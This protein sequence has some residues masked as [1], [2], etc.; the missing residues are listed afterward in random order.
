MVRVVKKD[1]KKEAF[2][3]KKIKTSVEKA[4]KE[5]GFAPQ[6]IGDLIQ[7]VAEP[8]IEFYNKKKIVKTT[9]LRRSL[10]GRLDRKAKKVSTA[11]RNYDKK[12][13]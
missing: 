4:A 5:A 2:I 3:P 9:D 1:G 7:E 6:R 12:K 10:L 8:V 11:W 13:K